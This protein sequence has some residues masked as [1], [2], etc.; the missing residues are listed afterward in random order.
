MVFRVKPMV[1]FNQKK[2]PKDKNIPVGVLVH[3]HPKG[4]I[5]T[6][7]YNGWKKLE[8]TRCTDAK[9]DSSCLGSILSPQNRKSEDPLKRKKKTLQAM[10]P[11]DLTSVFQTLDVIFDKPSKDWLR[12]KWLA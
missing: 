7:F 8:Q 2:I 9:K 10:I 5:K 6:A 1:I 12:R 4:W 3:C 11:G